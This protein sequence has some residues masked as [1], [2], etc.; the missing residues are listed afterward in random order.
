MLGHVVRDWA[1][2]FWGC[3]SCVVR[4]WGR[5]GYMILISIVDLGYLMTD[6]ISL[7]VTYIL[8][9]LIDQRKH[10]FCKSFYKRQHSDVAAL[11]TQIPS[12]EDDLD[13]DRET[14]E[15]PTHPNHV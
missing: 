5:V 7:L 10:A 11:N 13:E 15:N 9:C 1:E 4:C 3:V 8:T 2:G 14:F 12:D 6:L